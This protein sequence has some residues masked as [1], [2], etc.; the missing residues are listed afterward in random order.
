MNE[1]SGVTEYAGAAMFGFLAVGAVA[2]FSFISVAHWLSLRTEERYARDRFAMMKAILEHPGEQADRVLAVWHEQE[3][4][5]ERQDRRGRIMGGAVTAAVGVALAVMLAAL[6]TGESG[7]W[8]IGLIPLAV[9]V[10]IAAFGLFE[11]AN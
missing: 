7:I 11:K 2:L 3:V 9:G 8:T 4:K 1:M 10:V 6:S 5:K